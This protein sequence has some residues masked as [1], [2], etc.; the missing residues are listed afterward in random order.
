[1]KK[2]SFVMYHDQQ[3]TFES[4]PD[5]DAGKLIKAIFKYAEGEEPVLEGLMVALFEGFRATLDRDC[6][7]YTNTVERNRLNGKKGGRPKRSDNPKEPSGLKWEPK[8]PDSDSGSGIES[9]SE[10]SSSLDEEGLESEK[11][12]QQSKASP[13]PS[14]SELAKEHT[15]SAEAEQIRV[16]YNE[17]R[18]GM[19]LCRKLTPIRTRQINA[20][21]N[22]EGLGGLKAII[23]SCKDMP[24]LQGQNDRGWTADLEWLTKDSNFTKVMEGKYTVRQAQTPQVQYDKSVVPDFV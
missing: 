7:K 1:M 17:V 10:T 4:M 3:K 13:L 12:K 23:E 2:R 21:L 5:E 8:Q 24:H 18:G 15:C 9:D 11:E 22:E 16:W 20:R 19:P 14:N 6:E